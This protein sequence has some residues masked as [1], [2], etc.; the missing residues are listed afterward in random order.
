MLEQFD[1]ANTK[2]A[3]YDDAKPSMVLINLGTV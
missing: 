2:L 3:S 1:N